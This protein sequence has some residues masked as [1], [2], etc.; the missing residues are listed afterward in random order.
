M[1]I[2]FCL[3]CL[4]LLFQLNAISQDLKMGISAHD[5]VMIRQDSTYYLFATGRGINV[6]SS[7]D[8]VHWKQEKRVFDLAP[9][10]AVDSVKGFNN[11]IWAPD[12][13]WFN[14]KY[15]LYYSVSMFG[16]NT[17]CIGVATNS[18]LHPDDPAY[19]WTDHGMV[20]QS[21]PGKTNWNA[22][23]PNLIVAQDGK[24]YLAFGSFWDG[25]KILKL[26]KDG[27]GPDEPLSKLQTIAKRSPEVPGNPIEA[28]FVFKKG[29]YYY[30]FCS[31]DY[32]CKGAA[33]S[34]KMIAGR[35]ENVLGPYL[36]E[37]GRALNTGGG[38][39]ILQGNKDWYGVGHNAVCTFEGEDYLVFHGYDAN[40]NSR[41]KLILR[42]LNW[43]RGWPRAASL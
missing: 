12:I 38:S 29:K 36:D 10:W 24:P 32:C 26:K 1:K 39:L 7:R 6:W 35:S 18:T 41:P 2:N 21:V 22:I 30:L 3:V 5:P 19:H 28:P 9:K 31:I 17:S 13:S 40:D 25:I 42:Q 37:E 33:S 8:R 15:Y 43:E 16:K 23:D 11:H 20:I 27:L 14:G 34:Y 4:V